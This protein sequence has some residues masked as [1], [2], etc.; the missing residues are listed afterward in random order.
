M[1]TQAH[2]GRFEIRDFLGRG[3]IGDVYLAWD[4]KLASEVALKLVRTAKTDPE[5]VAAERNGT[6]LQDAL[7]KVAPQVAAV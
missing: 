4:P 3:A 7:A 5:M 1:L 2:V 6:L